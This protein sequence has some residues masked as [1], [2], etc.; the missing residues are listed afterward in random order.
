MK[1]AAPFQAQLTVSRLRIIFGQALEAEKVYVRG[2][3]KDILELITEHHVA[4]VTQ[5]D[6]CCDI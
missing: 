6:Y 5:S 2:V 1:K 3:E 4:R